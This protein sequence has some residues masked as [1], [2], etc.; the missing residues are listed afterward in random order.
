MLAKTAPVPKLLLAAGA[1]ATAV[2]T[3]FQPVLHHQARAGAATGSVCLLLKAGADPTLCDPCGHGITPAHLA[4]IHGHFA[5]EALLSRATDD[6]RKKHPDRSYTH[7][8]PGARCFCSTKHKPAVFADDFEAVFGKL[9]DAATKASMASDW[10]GLGSSNSSSTST[11]CSSSTTTATAAFSSKRFTFGVPSS[12]SA[13]TTS[14]STPSG[15]NIWYF[16][17]LFDSND[18]STTADMTAECSASSVKD[19]AASTTASV[20]AADKHDTVCTAAATGAAGVG[21]SSFDSS[22]AAVSDGERDTSSNA[23]TVQQ[24]QQQQQQ[25]QKHSSHR[26]KQPC[27]NCQTPTTKL[28]RACAAVY[29]CSVDCQKVSFK[30]PTHRA[31]C[32]AK[33]NETM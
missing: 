13:T 27:A 20:T 19:A 6:Y 8:V 24:Q 7:S 32:E 29:Y 11:S 14:T 15:A 26:A 28:C 31:Q 21:S 2:D 10:E 22:T 16:D 12:S 4:G 9:G 23:T 25:Q 5:L 18:A 17:G 33:A 1:D 30:D 3:G